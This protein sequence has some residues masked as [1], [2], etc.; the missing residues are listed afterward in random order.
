MVK[1]RRLPHRLV[2]HKC[3]G[4]DEDDKQAKGTS[5][6]AIE[7]DGIEIIEPLV[8]IS[9]SEKV[10]NDQTTGNGNGRSFQ[11]SDTIEKVRSMKKFQRL[12]YRL[13]MLKCIGW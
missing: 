7:N 3:V 10:E 13:V 5:G 12:P 11:K 4:Y 6:D 9:S 2:M 1:L 8:K